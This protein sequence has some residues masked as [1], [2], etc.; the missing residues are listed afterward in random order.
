MTKQTINTGATP[1]DKQGDSLRGAFTKINS[2]FTELYTALGIN[3]DVTLN[4]GAFE[5]NGSIMT[6]TDSSA[7]VIDQAV[8]V[9]S[10]LTVGGDRVPARIP[11]SA[12]V[13]P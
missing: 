9:S 10:N 6:T 5:F 1:N 7:I 13:S 2:N 12:H 4:L 8:T 11:Q 3:A